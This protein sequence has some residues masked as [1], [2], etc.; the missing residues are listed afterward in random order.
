MIFLPKLLSSTKCNP[1]RKTTRWK[2]W[3]REMVAVIRWLAPGVRSH[4]WARH[5][6]ASG[7]VLEDRAWRSSSMF[8]C[9]FAA[10]S[11]SIKAWSWGPLDK[12]FTVQTSTIELNAHLA[13]LHL[14]FC[15]KLKRK[16]RWSS[17]IVLVC[18]TYL[19][20]QLKVMEISFSSDEAAVPFYVSLQ[21]SVR[22]SKCSGPDEHQAGEASPIK[23]SESQLLYSLGA[24]LWETRCPQ[25]S[26]AFEHLTDAGC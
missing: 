23:P 19:F 17:C 26:R 9:V 21:L 25:W 2:K 6:S 15:W 22:K 8:T 5:P 18:K 3:K 10:L 14:W 4:R 1:M 12:V 11:V 20:W 13:V 7:G 24:A 16:K